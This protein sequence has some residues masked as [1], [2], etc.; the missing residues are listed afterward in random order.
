MSAS[1]YTHKE[2]RLKPGRFKSSLIPLTPNPNCP[3]RRP[4]WSKQ[5]KIFPFFFIS[6]IRGLTNNKLAELDLDSWFSACF[7]HHMIVQWISC[8]M[9]PLYDIHIYW[10]SLSS[11][12]ATDVLS[13]YLGVCTH[14]L[15]CS[16]MRVGKPEKELGKYCDFRI[17]FW[18]L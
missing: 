9:I 16:M 13:G 8:R 6:Y 7:S 11:K 17:R 2:L 4:F 12:G 14:V 5:G 15:Q 10:I 18:N 3:W 1:F